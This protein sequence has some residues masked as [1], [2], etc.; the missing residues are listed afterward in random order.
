MAGLSGFLVVLKRAHLSAAIDSPA[1][2][3]NVESTIHTRS[4]VIREPCEASCA[5]AHET[6]R[7]ELDSA[8]RDLVEEHRRRAKRTTKI[9][10]VE[11]LVL[12]VGVA[13]RIFEPEQ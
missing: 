2:V 5:A 10:Q 3:W 8:G 9:R 6:L 13:D 11:T 1:G 7:I 4:C 12:A